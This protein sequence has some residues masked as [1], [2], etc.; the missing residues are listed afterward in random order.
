ML[1]PSFGTLLC[2]SVRLEI[3]EIVR[4]FL[5]TVISLTPEDLV[6]CVYLACNEVCGRSMMTTWRLKVHPSPVLN[7]S[8]GAFS[9]AVKEPPDR[10][11]VPSAAAIFA[12]RSRS[13][14]DRR[15]GVIITGR[16]AGPVS[17][18][19]GTFSGVSCRDR[20]L[21]TDVSRGCRHRRYRGCRPRPYRYQRL[22]TDAG[23]LVLLS[24]VPI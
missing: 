11:C 20:Q 1:L 14:S 12:Q 17:D 4:G 6:P 15:V 24:R 22:I 2:P 23:N 16:S 3:Q 7:C 13:A 5:C 19:A 21:K 10:L 9:F 18:A 8:F